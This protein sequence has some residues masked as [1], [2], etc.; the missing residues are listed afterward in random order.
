MLS[1]KPKKLRVTISIIQNGTL[2][3]FAEGEA[4]TFVKLGVFL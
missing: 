3:E 1:L 2:K 4:F